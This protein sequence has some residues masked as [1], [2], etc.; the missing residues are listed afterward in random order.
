MVSDVGGVLTAEQMLE[1]SRKNVASGK[2]T[3]NMSAVEKLLAQRETPIED[4]VQLSP[5]QKIIQAQ[6]KTAEKK[7]NY[8]ESDAYM[9]LKVQQLRGQL[10][11]YSTLP[12]L[13]PNGG[14]MAGIEAEIKGIIEQQQTK[15]KETLDKGKAKEDELKAKQEAL[16]A[17]LVSPDDMLAR[18]QGKEQKE[19]ISDAAKKLL[20]KVKGSTVNKS[21]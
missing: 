4:T 19:T 7:E 2:T 14:V 12:G 13:D 10:A 17:E 1:R 11:L 21:A 16:A 18:V 9:E 5:V 8:F 15:L 3:A 6:K 20:D